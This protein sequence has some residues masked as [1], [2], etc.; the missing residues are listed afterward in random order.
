MKNA[1]FKDNLEND[2][3][4][5]NLLQK[6]KSLPIGRVEFKTDDA[7]GAAG[8][9]Y[10]GTRSQ[11]FTDLMDNFKTHFCVI[12]QNTNYLLNMLKY[13]KEKEVAIE[14]KQSAEKV[15]K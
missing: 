9:D 7:G 12:V 5:Q 13:Y 11:F 4:L 8:M 2:L 15:K 6:M 10:G 14:E 3:E 1:D